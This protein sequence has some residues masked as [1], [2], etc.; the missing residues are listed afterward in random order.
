MYIHVCI[1]LPLSLSVSTSLCVSLP[2]SVSL[3]AFVSLCLSCVCLSVS[4]SQPHTHTHTQTH[5]LTVQNLR[6]SVRLLTVVRLRSKT[7]AV[8]PTR[9][10]FPLIQIA[11]LLTPI[12]ANYREI[13]P[14]VSTVTESELLAN[15]NKQTAI[16]I[17]L[18]LSFML[19]LYM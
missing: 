10:P 19:L 8:K 2:L 15:N 11:K 14:Y 5:T 3:S 1:Y 6:T 18:F 12:V 16:L 9:T 7:Y 17:R 4:L 13:Y